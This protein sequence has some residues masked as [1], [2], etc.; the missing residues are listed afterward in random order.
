MLHFATF[1]HVIYPLF[2]HRLQQ[3]K[4]S[5]LLGNIMAAFLLYEAAVWI[6]FNNKLRLNPRSIHYF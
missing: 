1:L 4:R 3:F 6:V 5:K 2:S